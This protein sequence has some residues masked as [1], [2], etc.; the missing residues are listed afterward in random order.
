MISDLSGVRP[1]VIAIHKI[2]RE[3]GAKIIAGINSLFV[4]SSLV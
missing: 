1:N 4:K 2:G 3:G